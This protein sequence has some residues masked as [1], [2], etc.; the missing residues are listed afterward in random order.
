[1]LHLHRL[2]R[3][4]R[5]AGLD[6]GPGRDVDGE[7]R[8]GHR[9]DDVGRP[10]R[11][12]R[13]PP[14]RARRDR[15]RA[16]AR[17][18]TRRSPGDVDDGRR[19]R[20]TDRGRRSAARP[21]G[22]CQSHASASRPRR[23]S[24][25]VGGAFS[26]AAAGPPTPIRPAPARRG[27]RP[28]LSS[29]TR[30][31]LGPVVRRPD[32]VERVDPCL[33][34]RGR[35]ARGRASAGSAGSWRAR[36]RRSSSSAPRQP[37]EGLGPV[38]AVGDDLGQH[39]VEPRRRPRRPRSIAGI[40]PDAVAGRPAQAL[41]PA[42]RR[43]EAVPRHPRR[44]GGPRRRG[45]SRRDV[46]LRRSPSGSP[47]AIRSWSATRSRPVTSSVT[48]MLDLEPRVHLEE[49]ELAAVVEQEL[50]RARRSRSRPRR[51]SA[52]AA[53][54][55]PRRGAPASTAGDGVSSRTFWWRRWIEQSRSPRWTPVAV[56]VEQDL[57]LDV[58]RRPRRA[59][60]GSAG[61]RRRRPAPRGA[62]RRAR[63]R[64][65]LEV[66]DDAHPLAAAAGRGLDE[67]RVRRSRRGR[68][69][70]RRR[71]GRRRRSRRTTGT[72]SCAASRRAAALSPIARIAAGG[73]P[74]Q[75]DA[76][77]RRRPRRT[78]RSRRGTRS[79]DGRRR[80]RPA[81]RPRRPRSIRAGR[82]RPGRPSRARSRRIPSRSHV[83]VIRRAIS[84]RFAMKTRRIGD[85]RRPRAAVRPAPPRTRQTR[86]TRHAIDHQRVAQAAVPL[87]IQRWT[88]RV[89]VPSR[90]AASLG[91]SSS[92]IVS[93]LSH[94]ARADGKRS[95]VSRAWPPSP[96]PSRE[97]RRGGRPTR[98]TRLPPNARRAR[99]AGRPTP[100]PGPGRSQ[101]PRDAGGSSHGRS[102][103]P[104]H[105]LADPDQLARGP[106]ALEDELQCDEVDP[107]GLRRLRAR[108]A[109]MLRRIRID[110]E[111]AVGR[112]QGPSSPPPNTSAP[113]RAA[114]RSTPRSPAVACCHPFPRPTARSSSTRTWRSIRACPA[115]S[116]RSPS[117]STSSRCNSCS[118]AAGRP[119]SS[120][121]SARPWVTCSR[122]CRGSSRRP[123]AARSPS[124]TWTPPPR[125]RSTSSRRAGSKASGRRGRCITTR[126]G[127]GRGAW[128]PR[129]AEARP[130]LRASRMRRSRH[131]VRGTEPEPGCGAPRGH[132]ALR[133]ALDRERSAARATGWGRWRVASD[134][135]DAFG[136]EARP[137]RRAAAPRPRS[138]RCS[139]PTAARSRRG[140]RGPATGS[141][142]AR[143]C[144]R[145][146]RP[147][148]ARPAR[149]RRRRRGRASPPAPTRV[150]PGFGFLAENADF[151]EA[152]DRGRDP[153]G[154]PAA[155]GDP[156][157]GRQGR[158]PPARRRRSASRSLARLRRRRPVGRGARS[159][160][161]DAD[162]LPAARQAGG[163]RRRQG[164]AHRP[165]PRPACRDALAAARREAAGGVR[166]RP[167]HPRAA[168][169]GRRATSRS[170][171][172]STRTATASTSAS[173]TARSSAATR[174]SSR[175]RR[176]RPSTPAL[177]ERL[178][179]GRPRARR[180]R[181]A[182]SSAGTCEFLLDDR[183]ASDFLEMNTRLQV[184]HPVTELVT[185]RDLVADQLRI[186]AGEPLGVR[187]GATS[188]ATGHAI[189][190]RLYAEDAEDGFLPATG[191]IEALRWPA[192]DGHPGR[193]RD[194][195][196]ATRSAAGSTRCSPRSSPGAPTAPT[197]LDRLTRGARRRPS[198]SGSSRTCGS[199][200]GS[201]AS[202][203]SATAQAR[204][205]TLDADL[206]AG[207][208]GGADRDPGRG[209]GGGRRDARWPTPDR[210]RPVGRRLAAQRAADASGSRP[211]DETRAVGRRSPTA[212]AAA[213]E[214]ARR[215]PATPSTSTSPAG[216][217]R[218]GSRR[219][220]TSIAPRAPRRPRRGAR[221]VRPR[222]SPRCPARSSPSTSRS[223]PRSR[224]ATRSS[225]SRR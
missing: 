76:G 23:S 122:T 174:R 115:R 203:S 75:R 68:R 221:P 121:A 155:G 172:C 42:G 9:R 82:A 59:A 137:R 66:A 220:P 211:T 87:A 113:R 46:G 74:T 25:A 63:R 223:G 52:S 202:R 217:S 99:R 6:R 57:D 136:A 131:D 192:G 135:I 189:E 37:V 35:P 47:A 120:S 150:H 185:G 49:G 104:R 19:R 199:C 28:R 21:S 224:P 31:A 1:M 197:A 162:R 92:A 125:V 15:R 93:R 29:G 105:R 107:D 151:A 55:Q 32:P 183:G 67:Q 112:G 123:S 213:L 41:D 161:A 143:S 177:R 157:D 85:R 184:E 124:R 84:P 225:P 149:H 11:P 133:P 126:S 116:P 159:R 110:D 204:T 163:R 97:A 195:R 215:R 62:R 64:E 210:R 144:P 205:D 201:S 70:A 206:A 158:R 196:A 209:L 175:R 103:R 117:G 45:P 134:A 38:G 12:A 106:A 69:S 39:R 40:D 27:R 71:T 26:R 168:R 128:R 173:A 156:G 3:H 73:G 89:V 43:Q 193:R 30:V 118:K 2:E 142:S 130:C 169:R 61:R 178:G 20:S 194:R 119:A 36:G 140:S 146:G 95:I 145:H 81:R 191:R 154:R 165:R 79:R 170:R 153:L 111:R 160:A 5:V 179:D 58:A 17:S 10:H 166:R 77:R 96:R 16:A 4:D 101:A 187:A 13:W 200:A 80:R 219:R 54:A 48:G 216:A 50:A 186:A 65:P 53:V 207:R 56:R 182:T 33:R 222:S 198:S 190:V 181:S 7:H 164:H 148:R 78:R 18:G 94:P 86:Q 90:L 171:S 132:D 60:R 147:G 141:A 88:D 24:R 218:S 152:V 180:A 108:H 22:A 98:P 44:R 51:A 167:A 208:L 214:P 14:R 139:S 100:H 83:R 109:G 138:G 188:T 102:E 72:P 127:D 8:A 176:R 34:R 114:G 129:S 212:D 91:L